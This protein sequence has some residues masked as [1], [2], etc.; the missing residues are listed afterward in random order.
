M[1]ACICIFR[2]NFTTVGILVEL[3]VMQ[4]L[5]VGNQLLTLKFNS[6]VYVIPS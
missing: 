2:G 5:K 6:L 1:D 4:F 3:G